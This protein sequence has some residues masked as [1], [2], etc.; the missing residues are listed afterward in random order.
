M[1]IVGAGDG[2]GEERNFEG[3][4][5]AAMSG[6]IVVGWVLDIDHIGSVG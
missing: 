3:F 4:G 6:L 5:G 2:D 1:A